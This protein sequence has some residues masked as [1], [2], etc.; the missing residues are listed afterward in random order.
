M[1]YLFLSITERQAHAHAEDID[2]ML[3]VHPRDYRAHLA[4]ADIDAGDYP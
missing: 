1:E 4:R 3:I 2:L